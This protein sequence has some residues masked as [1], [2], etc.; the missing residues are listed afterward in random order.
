VPIKTEGDRD[1]A[2]PFRKLGPDVF[3]RALDQALLAGRIDCA[4]HSAKDV[5]TCLPKGIE[6]CAFPERSAPE[7]VLVFFGLKLKDSVGSFRSPLDALPKGAR[8]GTSSLRRSALLKF[9][10][11]DLVIEELRGNLETRLRRAEE[12]KLTAC[13]L[14]RAG[15]CRAG[16]EDRVGQ[17]LDPELFV[18]QAGQGALAVTALS[19]SSL[20]SELMEALDHEP[21]RSAVLSERAYLRRLGGGCRIPAGAFGSTEGEELKLTA[22]LLAPDGSKC[23]RERAKGK[24]GEGEK[25]GIKLAERI[26][27]QGGEEIVKELRKS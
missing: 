17:I 11:K 18:P 12:R 21:T 25:L 2:S 19:G 7:D 6:I 5:P 10:R 23:I 13:V 4:V 14:A 20:A 26:L 24:A 3:T 1:K 22:V 16:L 15:L 27:A 9:L 8:V